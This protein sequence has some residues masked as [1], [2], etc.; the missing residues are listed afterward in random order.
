[1]PLSAGAL[2]RTGTFVN[3]SV[4]ISNASIRPSCSPRRPT[5]P[6]PALSVYVIGRTQRRR[7]RLTRNRRL[8]RP[9]V[10][11]E[12]GAAATV[13]LGFH[14]DLVIDDSEVDGVKPAA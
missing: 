5:S 10:E 1:M 9:R 8:F 6:T 14:K 7:R 3:L 2:M 11:H 13:D 12:V 4:P